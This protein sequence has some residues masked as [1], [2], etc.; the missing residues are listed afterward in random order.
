MLN[1]FIGLVKRVMGMV[2]T[3]DIKKYF[4]VDAAVTNEMIT[5]TDLWMDM[6][7][8]VSDGVSLQLPSSIASEIA[9]LATIEMQSEISGSGRAGYL[10]EQYQRIKS[11]LRVQI[12]YGCAG[13]GLALKPYISNNSIQ[14]DFV[15][16]NAF[17]PTAFDNS[18]RMSGAVFSDKIRIGNTYYTRL[19]SHRLEGD[20]YTVENKAFRSDTESYIGSEAP[21]DSVEAWGDIAPEVAISG[22]SAPL[23]AYFKVPI[24]NIIDQQSPLGTSVYS[25]AVDLIREA[26]KQFR[27]LVWEFESGERAV[28]VDLAAFKTDPKTHKPKLPDKRLYRTLNVGDDNFFEDWSPAFREA[29]ILSGLN[30]MLQTIEYTC[31]LAYGTLSDPQNVDKTAEEIRASKQRSYCLISDVQKSLQTALDALI[32]AMDVYCTLYNLAPAGRYDVSYEWD[33]SIIADRQA[34]FAERMQLV[35][36]RAMQPWELRAWYLGE[37]EEVAKAAVLA[38]RRDGYPNIYPPEE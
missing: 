30:K 6:Y 1:K 16:A 34:E 29:S 37:P 31:G 18:G 11:M 8:G 12:E 21:L 17:V 33:D 28:Y 19:E 22:V 38:D 4:G 10:N 9:R 3:A 23:F 2:G 35:T 27:R 32:Y 36:M 14:V 24:A 26:D 25:R 13:G 5:A 15:K 20:R 7:S